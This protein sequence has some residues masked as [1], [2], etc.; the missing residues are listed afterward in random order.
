MTSFDRRADMERAAAHGTLGYKDTRPGAGLVGFAAVIL[1]LAGIW[2]LIEGILAIADS[3]VYVAETT[4]V[5]SDLN[6]WGWIVTGLGVLQLIAAFTVLGGSEFGRWFGIAAASLSAI[7]QLF[8]MSAYPF[9]GLV[10]FAVDLIIIYALAVY[11]GKQLR[12]ET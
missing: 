10:M 11:G 4:F 12:I 9:W 3:R 5:F 2:H 1:G 7:G 6:S 8:F